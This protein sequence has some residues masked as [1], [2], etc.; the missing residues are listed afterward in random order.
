MIETNIVLLQD[1]ELAIHGEL[2]QEWYV[3]WL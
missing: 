3:T 1:A 2:S